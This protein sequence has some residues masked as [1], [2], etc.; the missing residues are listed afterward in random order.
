MACKLASTLIYIAFVQEALALA[1]TSKDP[2]PSPN[3]EPSDAVLFVIPIMLFILCL[4]FLLFRRASS[5]RTVV[6]HQL[7]TWTHGEGRIRLSSDG[8]SA[9][10]FVD[11]DLDLDG[12]LVDN[13]DVPVRSNS[14]NNT[15]THSAEERESANAPADSVGGGREQGTSTVRG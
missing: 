9:S 11:Q 3:P 4:F 15:R 14:K 5:L 12:E 7:R 8:P 10:S 13:P 1:V 6:Q 2:R